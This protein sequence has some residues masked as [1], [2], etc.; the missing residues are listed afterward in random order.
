[1]SVIEKAVSWAVAIAQDDSH[2]YDQI[3]RWCNP[4][5]DCSSLVIL[6][7][8]NAGLKVREAGATYTGDMKNAFI[9]CG[10][11]AVPYVKG[12]TLM[13][14]DVLLDEKHH[15]AMY[16][17]NG[18][19]V[20]ASINEKGTIK[21]GRVGDQNGKEVLVR[22]FYEFSKGWD[23]ILRYTDNDTE[24]KEEVTRTVNIQLTT[25]TYGAR[26]EEVKTVQRLLNALN[27]VGANGKPLT[28][29]GYLGDNVLFAINKLQNDFL[30]Y[31]DGTVGQKT[32]NKLLK[33]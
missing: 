13:R 31:H 20:Q 32:W 12:M 9:K 10:F 22:S 24:K 2:G 29:D 3:R 6:S 4:D 27:Y 8:E 25:L 1:M 18:Q 16:I 26:G 21:G 19:I 17:G 15:T 14:G 5:V 7:F 30:G 28:V 33:G 11:E 23:C